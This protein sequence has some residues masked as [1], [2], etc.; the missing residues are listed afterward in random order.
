MGHDGLPPQ[1]HPFPPPRR[2]APV[3]PP[4]GEQKT[5]K[6]GGEDKTVTRRVVNTNKLAAI[7]LAIVAAV[8]LLATVSAG[9]PETTYVVRAKTALP[10][11]AEVSRSQLEAVKIDKTLVEKGAYQAETAEAAIAKVLR[12][13]AGLK[14][15]QKLARGEQIHPDDFSAELELGGEALGPDERLVSVSASIAAA[16]GGTLRPGDHVDVIAVIDDPNNSAN[17]WANVA[18]SDAEVVSVRLGE[19]QLANIAQSQTSDENRSKSRDELLPA[20]PIPGTYVLR[21]TAQEANRLAVFDAKGTIYL[22]FRGSA[23]ADVPTSPA[24]LQALL[25]GATAGV[26]PATPG[27]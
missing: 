22:S 2:P 27:D 16:A 8:L 11:L 21:V 20:D 25:G 23:A 4:L 1:H 6:K 15:Q 24:D 26:V 18:V 19:D 9:G 10:A 14:T 7:G 13:T 5:S 3:G 12:D 17:A